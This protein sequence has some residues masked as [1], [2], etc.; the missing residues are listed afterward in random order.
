QSGKMHQLIIEC[1][2]NDRK[3]INDLQSGG[4]G[5]DAQWM[6]EFHHALRVAAGQPKTGYYAD[7]NGVE[8]LAKSYIDAY[9]YDGIYS[10][11]RKKTFGN[12]T[13]NNGGEQFIV[14]SQNHDQVGN[15]MLGERSGTLY[16]TSMQ[17]L[18]AA[19]VM[20]S[21][22]LPLL[23]MGEEWGALNPFLYFTSHSDADL[24]AAVRKGRAD[25]FK[26]FHIAGTAPDPQALETF[27]SSK[28]SWELLE[29]EP[30]QQIFLFYKEL[31]ALRKRNSILN[32]LNRK[33]LTSKPYP[34][35]NSLV[36]SR[37]NEE[38]KLSF[39]LNFSKTMQK[40]LLPNEGF[41]DPIMDSSSPKYGGTEESQI[42]RDNNQFLITQPESIVILAAKNV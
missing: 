33:R 1:D 22:Y 29:Q 31:I 23:F 10:D 15:R 3:Y 40:I 6:D 27:Q 18:L 8:H 2:L 9:V 7:F 25:E 35:Q 39:V 24:I 36:I 17:K 41:W 38:E 11:E 5:M 4:Y 20:V 34:S 21:P 19:A 30:H 12:K 28:L 16:S 26:A 37:W 42:Q 14:F 13:T 32:N